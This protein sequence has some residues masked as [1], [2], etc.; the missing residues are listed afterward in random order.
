MIDHGMVV[1]P[2]FREF[3]CNL[4]IDAINAIEVIAQPRRPLLKHSGPVCKSPVWGH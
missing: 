2:L 4:H 3:R 1:G